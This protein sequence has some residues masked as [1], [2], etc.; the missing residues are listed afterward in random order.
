MLAV[1][2]LDPA[3]EA[4]RVMAVVGL[5]D[6]LGPAV[7]AGPGPVYHLGQDSRQQL[8]AVRTQHGP[9]PLRQAGLRC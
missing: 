4:D 9:A 5:G 6:Q 1:S 3:G 7:I 2:L 8:A